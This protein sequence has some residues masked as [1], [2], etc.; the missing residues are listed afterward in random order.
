[1]HILIIDDDKEIIE[2]TKNTLSAG[3]N[4][5]VDS[6]YDGQEAL[7]QMKRLV[8]YDL[9]ILAVL[10]PKLSGIDVC[11]A[12]VHD[13]KLKKIPVLLMSVLPLYSKSFRK[14]LK[15]FDELSVVKGIL[16]KPFSSNELMIKIKTISG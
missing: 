10:I 12:M 6:V 7:K 9:I 15:K 1:M 5:E 14:S 13:E 4:C 8:L 3:M 11:K 16:E 2:L